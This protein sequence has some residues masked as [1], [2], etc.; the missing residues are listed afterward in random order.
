MKN[1][2]RYILYADDDA[3][4]QELMQEVMQATE[5]GIEV[6]G[7]NNGIEVMDF[8]AK[9]SKGDLLPSMIVLDINMP[10]VGGYQALK[11]LKLNPA[12]SH[13][14]V[15]IFSTTS[16]ADEIKKARKFGAYEFITKP[17][18]YRDLQNVCTRIAEFCKNEPEPVIR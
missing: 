14:P 8:L 12:F 16:L 5:S 1:Y 13:I 18:Y 2:G 17:L 3:D 4:D 9:L 7:V 11:M 15:T 10:V 6:I